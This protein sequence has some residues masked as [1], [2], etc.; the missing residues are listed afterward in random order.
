MDLQRDFAD[1]E[2]GCRLLV[3]KT[4]DHQRQHFALARRQVEIVS[5]EHV[6]LGAS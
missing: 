2:F 4:A 5:F 1:P 3:E 6:E